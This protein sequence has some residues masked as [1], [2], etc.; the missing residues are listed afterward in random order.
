VGGVHTIRVDVRLVVATNRDLQKEVEEG[1]FRED[2]YYRL[3]VVPVRLPPLRERK[4]DIPLL[5]NHFIEKFNTKLNR[6]TEK[7]SPEALNLV[8]NYQWPGN[9]RELE[10]VIERCILFSEG[11]EIGTEHLPDQLVE[12]S[13]SVP[14]AVTMG[15]DA[16]MKDIVKQATAELERDLIV[17][18][19]EETKGNVT[20]A[21]KRLKISRK[22]LQNKMKEFGLRET[23]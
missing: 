23:D 16:S 15:A 20:R 21:A 19:L 5:V 22:S 14:T 10:N 8:I 11:P 12:R 18:A 3:N 4:E 9:I 6:K 13:S 17:K 7:L 1:R 2:L